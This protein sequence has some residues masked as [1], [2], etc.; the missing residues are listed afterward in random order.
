MKL[1]KVKCT[2]GGR[3]VGLESDQHHC[4]D[5]FTTKYVLF[6]GEDLPHDFFTNPAFKGFVKMEITL[7][8][9][10]GPELAYHEVMV[11]S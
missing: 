11:L 10:N 4:L 9:D 1:Y 8:A 2:T 3:S 5:E 7:L 6:V